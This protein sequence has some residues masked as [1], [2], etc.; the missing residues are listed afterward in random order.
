MIEIQKGL[1]Y[2]KTMMS[3]IG[4]R[5]AARFKHTNISWPQDMR[6]HNAYFLS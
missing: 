3:E 4:A 6:H 5:G 2:Q 1:V